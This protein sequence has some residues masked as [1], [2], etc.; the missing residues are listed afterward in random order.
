[1]FKKINIKNFQIN[2]SISIKIVYINKLILIINFSIN[3]KLNNI[4]KNYFQKFKFNFCFI[5][6]L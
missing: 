2:F 4:K 5:I 1:M 6:F 3:K